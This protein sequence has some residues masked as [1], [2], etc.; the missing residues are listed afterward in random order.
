MNWLLK[1][2]KGT[3]L[4]TYEVVVLAA[5]AKAHEKI[6]GSGLSDNEKNAV[7]E[8][9]NEALDEVSEALTKELGG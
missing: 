1:I 7:K 4:R 5:R 6:D 3:F 9:V 8:A 2:L